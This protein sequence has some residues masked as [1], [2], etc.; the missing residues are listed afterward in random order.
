MFSPEH[1]ILTVKVAE[2]EILGP[3][4]PG[5]GGEEAQKISPSGA[6]TPAPNGTPPVK[7]RSFFSAHRYTKFQKSIQVLRIRKIATRGPGRCIRPYLRN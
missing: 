6:L 1:E 4:G 3:L 5:R 2:I 7:N